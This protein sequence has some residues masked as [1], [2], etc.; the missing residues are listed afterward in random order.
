MSVLRV[1]L[2]KNGQKHAGNHKKQGPDAVRHPALS[3]RGKSLA[4]VG[5]VV[6]VVATELMVD[7]EGFLLTIDRKGTLH[8]VAGERQPSIVGAVAVGASLVTV[9]FH[10]TG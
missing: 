5:T 7:A 6:A 2:P 4:R 10:V 3:A 1:S 9:A 8:L